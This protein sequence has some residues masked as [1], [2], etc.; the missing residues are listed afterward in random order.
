MRF[1]NR[2][3]A[4]RQLGEQLL[5][6]GVEASCVLALPRGGVPVGYE[7]AK[8]LHLPLDVCVVRKLGV[9]GQEELAFGAI[10][11]GGVRVLSEALVRKI[12]I[13]AA[14]IEAV[15]ARETLELERRELRYRGQHTSRD[16]PYDAPILVDDGV[17]TGATMRAAVLGLRE[18]GCEQ[19]IIAVPTA[20]VDTLAELQR[21]A[22]RV[23]CLMTPEPFLSVGVWYEDFDQTS[24]AEVSRLLALAGDGEEVPQR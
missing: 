13:T 7:V 6:A 11:S 18:R 4:G 22:D 16:M 15:T 5:A 3:E 1:I 10:A 9:P 2:H 12:G 21:Y 20:P 19:I 24:D 17:A 23:I 8:A 14:E